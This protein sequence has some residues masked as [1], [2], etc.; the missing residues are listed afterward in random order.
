MISV[1]VED[2]EIQAILALLPR[3][4]LSSPRDLHPSCLLNNNIAR[5]I[6][7]QQLVSPRSTQRSALVHAS[8]VDSPQY[9]LTHDRHHDPI[10]HAQQ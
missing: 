4:W 7:A 10:A 3:R 5:N 8:D 2:Y 9:A 1:E 6:V